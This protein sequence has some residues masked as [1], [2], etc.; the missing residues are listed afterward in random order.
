MLAILSKDRA[1]IVPALFCHWLLIGV[2][3]ARQSVVEGNGHSCDQ[4]IHVEKGKTEAGTTE[5]FV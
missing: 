5:N 2:D 4:M 1:G 3:R